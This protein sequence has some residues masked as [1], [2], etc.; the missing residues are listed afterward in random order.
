MRQHQLQGAV[1]CLIA[2]GSWGVRKPA[3]RAGKFGFVTMTTW[4]VVDGCIGRRDSAVP[5]LASQA[6]GCTQGTKP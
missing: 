2:T 3:S 4:H 1:Y 5:K 6:P